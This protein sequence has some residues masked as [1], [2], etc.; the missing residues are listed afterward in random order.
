MIIFY[1]F[2]YL[3]INFYQI[4][5]ALSLQWMVQKLTKAWLKNKRPSNEQKSRQVRLYGLD[6]QALRLDTAQTTGVATM[7]GLSSKHLDRMHASPQ[8]T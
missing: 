4:T 7:V 8:I 2:I 1:F 3:C 6:L 5:C